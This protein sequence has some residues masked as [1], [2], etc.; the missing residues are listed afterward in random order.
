MFTPST[1]SATMSRVRAPISYQGGKFR[2]LPKIYENEPETFERFVDV[3]GGAGVVSL[4]YS[5]REGVDVHYNDTFGPLVSMFQILRDK[6]KAEALE[7]RLRSIETSHELH[8]RICAGELGEMERLFYTSRCTLN[9]DPHHR[10]KFTPRFKSGTQ[11]TKPILP[12]SV[13]LKA[14]ADSVSKWQITQKD[15]LEVLQDYK[16]DPAA[17]LYLDP[18]YISKTTTQYTSAFTVRHLNSILEFMRDSNTKCKVLLT[19][20]YTG[21]TREGCADLFKSCYP[22]KYMSP[23]TSNTSINDIYAKWHLMAANF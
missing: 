13:N 14:Y 10:G 12:R 16:D 22:V 7:V 20:D 2:E 15:F 3:F 21:H 23:N 17:F 19:L 9:C 1:A 8:P 11:E 4:N 5:K 6:D 18:P